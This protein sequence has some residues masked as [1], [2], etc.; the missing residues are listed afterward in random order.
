MILPNGIA[1]CCAGRRIVLLVNSILF[2]MK[3]NLLIVLLGICLCGNAFG[4]IRNGYAPNLKRKLDHLQKLTARLSEQ[5]QSA[6][7]RRIILTEIGKIKDYLAYY[8]LTEAILGQLKMLSGEIYTELD[9]IRDRKQRVTDIYVRLVPRDEA[10]IKFS[11]ASF[12]GRSSLDKDASFSE[13]GKYSVSM[14]VW[15][16]GTAL[17]ELYHELGHV[18]YIIPNLAMY[19]TFYDSHYDLPN[20]NI[21]SIGHHKNDLSGRSAM[22]FERRFKLDRTTYIKN[23]GRKLER[24]F[25]LLAVIRQRMNEP[26]FLQDPAIAWN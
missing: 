3:L 23:T 11:A 15:I 12:I 6:I 18:K 24:T 2:T 22:D 19:S 1:T 16:T 4:K 20:V 17:Q 8:E 9:E 25:A 10:K 7:E 21:P 26:F 14:D 13:F 5:M